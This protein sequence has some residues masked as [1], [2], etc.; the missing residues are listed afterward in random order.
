MTNLLITM[1]EKVSL[2]SP[3]ED[4]Y[5]RIL[6]D[7]TFPNPKYAANKQHGYSN[8]KTKE[9][10]ETFNC[11][12]GGV[13]L[14]RGY[15]NDLIDL[16]DSKGIETSLEDLRSVHETTFPS[17]NAELRPYQKRAVEQALQ[18]EQGVI[19]SPTG[20]GKSLI[21]LDIIRQ[22]KQK[23]LIIVHRSDL[24][25]QW[26]DVILERLGIKSGFIGDGRFEI[27]N[28]ITIAMIQTLSSRADDTKKIGE[29][30][31]LLLIDEVH[32]IPAESFFEVVGGM[33]AK[34]L[35]GLSAIVRRRDGL[36]QMIYRSIGNIITTVKTEEVESLGATVPVSV[37]SVKTGFSPGSL[38]SW[39][40]YM[41]A[42]TADERRNALIVDLAQKATGPALILTD[43]VEHVTALSK[44]LLSIG[45]DHVLAHGQLKAADRTSVMANIK[46][47]RITI[48]TTGLLGEGL[49]VSSWSVLIMASPISSEIKLMQAIGRIVRPAPGKTKGIVYDLQDDCGFSGSSFNKRFEIYKKNSIWVDFSKK[50]SDR[51]SA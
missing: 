20:S 45:I 8:W 15:A 19:I 34:F 13:S 40:E 29:S 24:A 7:N 10:I 48:G 33:S 30:F 26:T 44:Q 12:N 6:S 41:S 50:N 23:T 3:P 31:G 42:I 36:E 49:D 16:C 32:H 9:T 25:K 18:V 43:R 46:T 5:L 11:F 14:P 51:R 47:A 1:K 17:L 38:N 35:Y 27:G 37:V 39:N 4:L 2:F 21:G 22:R 28:K